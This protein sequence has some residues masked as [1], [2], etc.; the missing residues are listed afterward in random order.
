M[1]NIYAIVNFLYNDYI[2]MFYF[3]KILQYKKN[4]GNNTL[5]GPDYDAQLE[6]DR[7]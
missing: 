2:L 1:K 5:K 6:I 4:I 7:A 3:L